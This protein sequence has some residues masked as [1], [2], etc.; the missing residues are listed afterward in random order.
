MLRNKLTGEYYRE[1]GWTK[2]PANAENFESTLAA[3][4][5]VVERQIRDVELI[6]QFGAD[7]SRIYD[8]CLPLFPPS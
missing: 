7:P 8:V 4:S 5:L 3:I 1:G 2:E 6:L